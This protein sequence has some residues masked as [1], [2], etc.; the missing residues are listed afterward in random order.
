MTTE[1]AFRLTY[2]HAFRKVIKT[3]N[4]NVRKRTSMSSPDV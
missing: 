2:K 4:G 3:H 1:N